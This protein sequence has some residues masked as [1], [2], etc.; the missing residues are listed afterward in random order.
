MRNEFL[1]SLLKVLKHLNLKTIIFNLRYLPFRVAIKFPIF[2]GKKVRIVKLKG[3]L[4]IDAP[5]KPGMIRIGHGFV[6]IFDKRSTYALWCNHGTIIFK[7]EA[8]IKFGAKINV[9][10][11]GTLILGDKFRIS[12]NSSIV[13]AERIELGVNNRIS[14]DSLII[15]TDYHRIFDKET[16][17]LINR[18]KG[19]KL[20][21][22]VWVG[23]RAT[24]QKGVK[25]NDNIIIASN[26][27]VNKSHYGTNQI[28]GGIPAKVIKKD[29]YW[30]E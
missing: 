10:K 24:I 15:D 4:I 23:Y 30:K 3:E 16:H 26:S 13:C 14:W 7:G 19:I 27:L 18:N 6:G 17:E 2:V 22:N 1:Y 25:L 28:L 8:L 29:V 20:G 21:N 11:G 5:I 12:C 9:D